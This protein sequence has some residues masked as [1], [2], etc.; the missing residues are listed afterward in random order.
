MFTFH[1]VGV[2]SRAPPGTA[3]PSSL[4]TSAKAG[5]A[6]KRLTSVVPAPVVTRQAVREP[7]WISGQL[8]SARG[9]QRGGNR[10][11]FVGGQWRGRGSGPVN[12]PLLSEK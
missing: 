3:S 1:S 4:L 7:E 9:S 6:R 2:V 11:G 10:A 5:L 12:L 8:R